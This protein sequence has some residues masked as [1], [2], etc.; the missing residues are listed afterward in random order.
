ML[1]GG[2]PSSISRSTRSVSSL[3][4]PVPAFAETNTE[5]AGS[6]AAACRLEDSRLSVYKQQA[7][8][9]AKKKAPS[10]AAW[11]APPR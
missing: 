1:S 6:D 9:V 8:L 10:R 3:V 11:L 7:N 2:A 5:D 4:F